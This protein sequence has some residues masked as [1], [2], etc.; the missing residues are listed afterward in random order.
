MS[1]D[2]EKKNAYRCAV[3][4]DNAAGRLRIGKKKFDVQVTYTSRVAFTIRTTPAIAK[5]IKDKRRCIL[6]HNGEK[7]EVFKE[8]HFE[9]NGCVEILLNR[10]REL[11]KI[12]ENKTSLAVFTSSQ[13]SQRDPAFLFYLMLAFL[14][15][16]VALPGLGDSI[17]TA[18]RIQNG[19]KI[20]YQSVNDILW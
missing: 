19:F 20:I 13:N 17:G 5:K 12:K 15:A 4:T 3:S 2:D 6:T 10:G 1:F 14:F 16:F 8:S 11:T 18:P 7:W 9:E